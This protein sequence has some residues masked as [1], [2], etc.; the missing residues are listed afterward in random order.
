MEQAERNH[1]HRPGGVGSE[2]Q[3]GCGGRR[4]LP[5]EFLR[6]AIAK[7]IWDRSWEE[8]RYAEQAAASTLGIVREMRDKN[9]S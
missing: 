7:Y 6:Q 3:R 1:L 5:S 9:H 8:I 2:N 4:L